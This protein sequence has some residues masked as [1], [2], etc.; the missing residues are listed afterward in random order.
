VESEKTPNHYRYVRRYSYIDRK[1]MGNGSRPHGYCWCLAHPGFLSQSLVKEH[2]CYKKRC[3]YYERLRYPEDLNVI[4]K[5]DK[6]RP[7]EL[8]FYKGA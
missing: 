2:K 5:I 7:K 8:T 1:P 3:T 4:K 6:K